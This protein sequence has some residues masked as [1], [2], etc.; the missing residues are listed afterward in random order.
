MRRV[1]FALT[2]LVAVSMAP[3][4][5]A[6]PWMIRYGFAEC[7]SCHIDPL[8]GETLNDMGRVMSETLLSTRWA[9]S[10]PTNAAKFLFGVPQPNDVYLGGS[11]R[12]LSLY[13]FD[14]GKVRAFPM[15]SDV[16]GA[17]ILGR[18]TIAASLGISKAS[19]LYDYS[20]KAKLIGNVEDEDYLLVSRNHWVGYHFDEHWMLRLGR[21]NLPFGLRVVE[22]TLW[23]RSETLTDRESDQE[24]AISVVYSQGPWRGEFLVSLG[25]FQIPNDAE[26]ERGYS[27]YME[28]LL[29]PNLALGLSSLVM[30][31]RRELAVQVDEGTVVRQAHGATLRFSP[32]EPVALL[33]EADLLAKTGA[34]V[35]YAGMAEIDYEPLQGLH[36]Q[37]IGEI[38]DRGEPPSGPGLGRGKPH[39]GNWLT[40]NW[41]FA[42]H[43]D[44]RVDLVSRQRQ[45][46][47]LQGQLHFSL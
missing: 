7:G 11:V 14:T 20:S 3:A 27:G 25:N 32:W 34:S 18:F 37:T 5:R 44:L 31:A 22:H 4:A 10:P 9:A 16:Y 6:Y 21:L 26:R 19:K 40:L 36:L 47:M 46:E 41:F 24:D 33:A 38:L 2:L 43:F 23:I 39:L 45:G 12:V 8:G 30:V 35:G 28:L 29:E 42:P 15:Q 13:G 1:L 17:G